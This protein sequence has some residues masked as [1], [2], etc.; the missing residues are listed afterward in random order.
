TEVA[1]HRKDTAVDAYIDVV[2][3]A[4]FETFQEVT[5]GKKLDNYLKELGFV[6]K[7]QAEGKA[8]TWRNAVLAALR[9]KF[10]IVPEHI[11][12][13]IRQMSDPIA[14][15][16]LHSYALDSQTLDEFADALK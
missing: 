5:M 2:A 14:L 6:D 7:W 16:S 15:E 13:V 10:T 8:E 3:E 4:N 12:T 11:E 9:K 1:K